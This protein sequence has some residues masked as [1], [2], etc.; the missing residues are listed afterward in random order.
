MDPILAKIV[1]KILNIT[2]TELETLIMEGEADKKTVKADAADTIL[3]QYSEKIIE[4]HKKELTE[5]GNDISG[6]ALKD[7]DKKTREL[8]KTIGFETEAEKIFESG[9]ELGT[10][11]K[12][13]IKT[14]LTDDQIKA[15]PLYL[16]LEKSKSDS[17]KEWEK[18]L[19]T[20]KETWTNEQKKKETLSKVKEIAEGYILES[21]AVIPT[22]PV[23][24]KNF[25]NTFLNAQ[26]SGL[27]YEVAGNE[28]FIIDVQA[29]GTRKRRESSLGHA[30]SF[31]EHINQI[32]NDNLEINKQAPRGNAG[33][34]GE[35]NGGEGGGTVWHFEDFN[36]YSTKV[37]AEPD[38]AKRV[39]MDNAWQ[40]Q[41]KS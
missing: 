23:K 24:R 26:L 11:F 17:D 18:K 12:S 5:K 36:D 1:T 22:D 8:L 25:L 34:G 38:R 41:N 16:S 15:S 40:A 33:N 3:S 37:N 29:D 10:F 39:E 19:T 21:K 32:V 27:E 20:E 30:V 9:E 6:K 7:A 2:D 31:K 35:G 14:N 13:K 28:I 4:K